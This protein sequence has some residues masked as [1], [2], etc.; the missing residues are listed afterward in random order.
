MK[1]SQ[2]KLLKTNEEKM[3]AFRPEQMFMKTNELKIS[4]E[5][6]IEK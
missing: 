6:V 2:Q 1:V 4:S 3:S 5:Y